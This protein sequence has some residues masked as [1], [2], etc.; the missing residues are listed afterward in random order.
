[1]ET[2]Q[3][4][5]RLT[6]C[7]APL[8]DFEL[9]MITTMVSCLHSEHRKLDILNLRLAL[10]ATRLARDPDALT[11]EQREIQLWDEIRQVLWSHLQIENELVLSWGQEHKAISGPL[12]DTLKGEFA[13][14]R[15]AVSGLT[16]SSSDANSGYGEQEDRADF[17][18]KLLFF[19]Q[20]LDAH[21]ER[22]DRE[23]LPSILR[24]V[25]QSD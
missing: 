5:N 21:I 13:Q 6:P 20:A 10:A 1:M 2:I 18:R 15:N 16:A 22:Y 17:A 3:A 24:A 7:D 19:S 23:V 4:S 25:F 11:A 9:P 12:L 8:P 14:M